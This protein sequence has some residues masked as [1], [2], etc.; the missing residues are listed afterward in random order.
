MRLH[1]GEGKRKEDR[2]IQPRTPLRGFIN[3]HRRVIC[4]LALTL[5]KGT[6]TWS[7][8]R[9]TYLIAAF[10]RTVM[11]RSF[12]EAAVRHYSEIAPRW[13]MVE[14]SD[15][16]PFA[17][18]YMYLKIIRG[19]KYSSSLFLFL[20][21]NIFAISISFFSPFPLWILNKMTTFNNDYTD[22][23]FFSRRK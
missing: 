5:A 3:C 19:K 2:A 21:F 4:P 14:R 10:I 13:F 23:Y 6:G 17:A 18:L 11:S 7:I 16:N 1:W 8:A 9:S 15:F 20:Q 22:T 12:N